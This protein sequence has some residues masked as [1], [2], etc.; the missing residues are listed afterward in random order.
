[1]HA[2]ERHPRNCCA[3]FV[4]F[5]YIRARAFSVLAMSPNTHSLRVVVQRVRAHHRSLYRL[6]AYSGNLTC[7]AEFE[8]LDRLL[9]ALHS[10]V[11]GFD[12]STLSI[13]KDTPETYI[14]FAGEMELDDSQLLLLGLKDGPRS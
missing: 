7:S 2:C 4:P 8:S 1:M 3:A 11:S 5:R 6:V 14:A 9:K 12:E 13:R 10:A